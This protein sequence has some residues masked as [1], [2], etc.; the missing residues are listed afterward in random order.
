MSD[1]LGDC[2]HHSIQRATGVH[3][4]N[5]LTYSLDTNLYGAD[6]VFDFFVV[7]RVFI[8]LDE[9]LSD[10][11]PRLRRIPRIRRITRGL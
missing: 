3:A 8:R 2:L 6:S 4:P 5:S 11:I 1:I 7:S 9:L 10:E